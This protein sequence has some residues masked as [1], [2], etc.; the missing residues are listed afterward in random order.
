MLFDSDSKYE[1]KEKNTIHVLFSS[2]F[3][4]FPVHAATG[5]LY[6]AP[7]VIVIELKLRAGVCRQIQIWYNG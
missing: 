5:H 1:Q 4:C 7:R 6:W 2:E 3:L